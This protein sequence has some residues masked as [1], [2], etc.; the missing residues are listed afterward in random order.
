MGS[1]GTAKYSDSKNWFTSG[2]FFL[3]RSIAAQGTRAKSWEIQVT[4]QS[5]LSLFVQSFKPLAPF[6]DLIQDLQ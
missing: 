3:G 1:L 6:I 2:N 5:I 4:K